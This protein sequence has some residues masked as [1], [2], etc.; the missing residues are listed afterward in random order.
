V[1]DVLTRLE[2]LTAEHLVEAEV[3]E[4]WAPV[5]LDYVQIGEALSNV[6][7]NAVKYTPPGSRITISAEQ[8]GKDVRLS[9]EDD[10]PGI[11]VEALPRVFEKFYRVSGGD[12]ARTKGTGLG[13]AI[14]RGFVEAHG[15]TLEAQSPPPG[16][17]RGTV[18]VM[19]LP[20]GRSTTVAGGMRAHSEAG[21]ERAT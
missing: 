13:L 17:E 10:G 2:P 19:T 16:K 3:P 7:E 20:L 12:G 5:P 8:N 21:A 15:G 4:A 11:S 18:F 1:D 6:V 14:A 9:V